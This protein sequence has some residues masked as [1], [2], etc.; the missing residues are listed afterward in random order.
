MAATT[1][2]QKLWSCSDLDCTSEQTSL[3]RATHGRKVI[4]DFF[5]RNKAATKAIPDDVWRWQC[6]KGYQ[7]AKYNADKNG[8]EGHRRFFLSHLHHQML[9]IKLWRPE[10]TFVV[11]LSQPAQERL[12]RY[13]TA[14]RHSGN[15]PAAALAA[16][17]QPA[18]VGR[19]EKNLLLTLANAVKPA[20]AD[21]ID[22][23]FVGP[24]RSVDFVIDNILP[25]INGEFNNGSMSQMPPVEFLIN[26]PRQGE[27]V[28]DAGG[29][30]AAWAASQAN[31]APTGAAPRPSRKRRASDDEDDITTPAPPKKLPRLKA[32]HG[33]RPPKPTASPSGRRNI[34]ASGRDTTP[35]SPLPRQYTT[36]ET[37][38]ADALLLLR[39]GPITPKP[40]RR[41]SSKITIA[42]LLNPA[43]TE[44]S[45]PTP[46]ADRSLKKRED[47][48]A[49]LPLFVNSPPL[50]KP[51]TGAAGLPLFVPAV[52]LPSIEKDDKPEVSS[53]IRDAVTGA[54]RADESTTDFDDDADMTDDDE[55]VEIDET[56]DE[57]DGDSETRGPIMAGGKVYASAKR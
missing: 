41:G 11:Q 14:L 18:K 25:W 42:S 50:P 4:S 1:A 19:A 10:C 39:H 3:P 23:H 36:A 49:R 20:H 26:D 33:P 38:A 48:V 57:D 15:D 13:H 6:R 28:N 8:A 29:N 2:A 30:F 43:P 52:I 45:L 37:D 27:T 7:R 47:A 54:E 5:G 51:K 55:E 21:H 34:F 9:R 22:T 40:S 31:Q 17:A 16:I 32:L 24:A 35:F 44:P 46:P 53:N 56:D 12:A